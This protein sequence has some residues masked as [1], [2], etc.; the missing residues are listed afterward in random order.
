[1][2]VYFV[3]FHFCSRLY[4]TVSRFQS[5]FFW[6]S[7]FFKYLFRTAGFLSKNLI[8]AYVVMPKFHVAQHDR[9]VVS[10][11]VK[12]GVISTSYTHGRSI[13][14]KI[15]ATFALLWYLFVSNGFTCQG[16]LRSSLSFCCHFAYSQQFFSAFSFLTAAHYEDM[17]RYSLFCA[18][19]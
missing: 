11:C 9:L 13:L 2:T 1:M 5:N 3:M 19:N 16:S 10:R 6:H 12:L 17:A 14:I 4:L 18:I 8:K 15:K 7:V